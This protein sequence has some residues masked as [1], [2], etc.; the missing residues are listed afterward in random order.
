M[1]TLYKFNYP[2]WTL[3][4]LY[5]HPDFDGELIR[6]DED[7][8]QLPDSSETGQPFLK[9][10]LRSL[11]NPGKVWSL[12]AGFARVGRT[13][14]ENNIVISE[15]WVSQ[16]HAEIFCRNIGDGDAA[17]LTYFLQDNSRFG[18]LLLGSDGWQKVHRQEVALQSGMQLKFGSSRGQA[19]EFVIEM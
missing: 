11:S 7:I 19:F 18:T 6:S 2:A 4:V 17:I 10:A 5:L 8:T 12:R 13:Q 9:A 3:P 14:T 16:Q 15:P 1:L